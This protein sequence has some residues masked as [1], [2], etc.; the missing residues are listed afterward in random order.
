L[1][2]WSDMDL[3]DNGRLTH[4]MRYDVTSDKYI[5]VA[6]EDAFER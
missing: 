4:P 3:E 2:T 5:S 1:R 6:W